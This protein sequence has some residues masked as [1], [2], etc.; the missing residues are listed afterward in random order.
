MPRILITGKNC[1]LS[2]ETFSRAA[3]LAF[4]PSPQ[5]RRAVSYS[6]AVPDS[7]AGG[8]RQCPTQ[9]D[10]PTQHPSFEFPCAGP[11]HP[12]PL[13]GAVHPEE[14]A[15]VGWLIVIALLAACFG[16]LGAM[17]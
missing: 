7:A 10:H 11:E 1:D 13:L 12:Q 3:R 6:G 9:E 8:S 16:V 5:T 17:A 15:I 4:A 2:R 14:W